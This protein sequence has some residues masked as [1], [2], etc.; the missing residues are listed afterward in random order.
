MFQSPDDEDCHNS[1]VFIAASA[2]QMN[3]VTKNINGGAKLMNALSV[4]RPKT[5]KDFI[6]AC[7]KAMVSNSMRLSAPEE[8]A[9]YCYCNTPQ[10][11][12]GVA[13]SVIEND[14]YKCVCKERIHAECLSVKLKDPANLMCASCTANITTPGVTWAEPPP[15]TVKPANALRIINTCPVDNFLTYSVMFEKEQN[16]DFNTHLVNNDEQSRNLYETLNLVKRGQFNAAQVKYYKELKKMN[17]DFLQLEVTKNMKDI[18]KQQREEVKRVEKINA[19][20]KKDNAAQKKKNKN[21]VPKELLPLPVVETIRKPIPQLKENDMWG[22]VEERVNAKH[23]ES[24][25][26]TYT[27]KCNNK[28]CRLFKPS[29]ETSYFHDFINEFDVSKIGDFVTKGQE[30]VCDACN[31]GFLTTSP[32]QLDENNWGLS[33]HLSRFQ[34]GSEEM[35]KAK[36][37]IYNMKVPQKITFQDGKEYGLAAVVFS[38]RE[39]HFVSA[40]WMPSAGEFVWY[41]GIDSTKKIRKCNFQSDFLKDRSITSLE[42]LRLG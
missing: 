21:F 31:N 2:A 11:D 12:I 37:D 3:L 7:E 16:K 30:R 35:Y 24:F 36:A 5:Y 23:A 32:L 15:S 18:Q 20:I 38:E 27:T 39:N 14:L 9:L 6:N 41:D 4:R 29:V 8:V 10:V 42:Y 25:K 22:T 13:K 1:N 40:I 19:E 26:L 17:D 28:E 33:I 34:P